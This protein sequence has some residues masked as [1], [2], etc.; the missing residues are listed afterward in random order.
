MASSFKLEKPISAILDCGNG[1]ACLTAPKIFKS[2]GIETTELYCDVHPHFPNRSSEPNPESLAKAS[3]L[4]KSSGASFGIGFD[5]DGDRGVIIDDAGRVLTADIVGLIIGQDMLKEKK[6]VILVNVESSMAVEE[7]LT[8]LGGEV[9]RIRVGH[10]FLTLEAK[11]Q[12]SFLGFE[13]SG[14]MVLPDYFLFDDAMLIPLKIAEMLSRTDRKLSELVDAI[15][16]YPKSTTNFHCSDEH[17][18][19]VIKS[20]QDKFSKT[21]DKVNILD[22]VRVDLEDGWTLMRVSNTEPT[23]RMTVEASSESKLNEL[24]TEFQGLLK[25]EIEQFSGN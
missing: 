15:P 12:K 2:L 14:H 1:S 18:F 11:R 8:P 7:I 4:V 24:V 16:M 22:G 10:T 17:K 5:G 9:N 6:G 3:E 25:N 19:S 20:L 13:R 23:I 21:Y